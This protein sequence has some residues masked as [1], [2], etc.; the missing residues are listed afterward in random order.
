MRRTKA[1]TT[2]IF[3]QTNDMALSRNMIRYLLLMPI[4]TDLMLFFVCILE[5]LVIDLKLKY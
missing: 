5:T 3:T 4:F 2:V 1:A